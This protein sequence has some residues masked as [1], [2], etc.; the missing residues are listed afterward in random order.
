VQLVQRAVLAA[1]LG[2][3][4]DGD[5]LGA[6]LEGKDPAAFEALVRRHGPLVL[7][8]CRQVLRDDAAAEDAFQATFVALYQKAAAIR[9]QPALGGWLFRVARRTALRARRA[10][11][12]RSR[13]EARANPPGISASD[14]SWR[15]ACD[16][17]H[18]ELD[19]LPETY[20]STLV[21][22]YL[23]G[24]PR[25]EAA[26]RLGWSVTVLRGRLERARLRLRD[27]LSKRGIT[28]SA[29]LMTA[30]A[31]QAVP[32]RLVESATNG[33]ARPSVRVAE[34][35]AGAV[36]GK[37]KSLAALALAAGIV[38][39]IGLNRDDARANPESDRA[40]AAKPGTA[41]LDNDATDARPVAGRV[42]DPDGKP[43]AGARVW[44]IEP[45]QKARA[46][47]RTG[48]DGT[49]RLPS[50][51]MGKDPTESEWVIRI[52]ATHERF[53]LGLPDS[54]P[55]DGLTLR[56]VKDD[57]PIH[58]RVLDLQ[59]QPVAGV[60]VTPLKVQAAAGDSLN[61]WLEKL[62]AAEDQVN[63][64]TDTAVRRKI[65]PAP[66]LAPVKTDAQGRFTLR[67]VGRERLVELR[68]EGPTV[69]TAEF[70]V[71]T[72]LTDSVRVE[73]DPGNV[74]LGYRVFYGATFDFAADPTQPFEGVVTGKDTGKPIP[75]AIVSSV[76]PN[77]IETVADREG[78]YRLI[79]LSAGVHRLVA[80]PPTGE[81]FLPFR[82]EGGLPNSQRPV[83]L[84]FA[85][86]RAPWAEGTV[87][88]ARTGKPIAGASLHYF[89]FDP[90]GVLQFSGDA[91]A[92]GEAGRTDADGRFKIVALPGSGA[93]GVY[94][95]DGPYIE[96]TRRPLQGDA[97]FWTHER[98][99]QRWVQS[100]FTSFHALAVVE[101]D[102]KKPRR[103][104]ITLDPGESIKG[105]IL[106][107]DGKPLAGCRA[108]RLTEH[109]GWTPKPLG[110]EFTV[111]QVQSG[112]ARFVLFWHEER[113]LGAI[114]RPKPGEPATY[115]VR[116]KPNGAATGKLADK[117]GD[118]LSDSVIELYFRMP[119]EFGWSPWFPKSTVRTDAN[120]RFELPNLPEGVEFMLRYRPK[121]PAES[122]GREFRVKSGEALDLG[123]V[124]PR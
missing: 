43:V 90:A 70:R 66:F 118:P 21:L 35:A 36:S 9:K 82:L 44:I 18:A 26:R 102:P 48:D 61:G 95:P 106:D 114:W 99:R 10:A 62:K 110:A 100:Y 77:R 45:W 11:D 29:G 4:T 30:L 121:F 58:G 57:V 42:L 13:H 34:L 32:A 78:R 50:D 52:V 117:D 124:K 105:R 24:L 5:L 80:R 67:G 12:R 73:Y 2:Q 122:H 75:G 27:R 91:E 108:A 94:G 15:E 8:A 6:F 101:L 59:G 47:A 17:L 89:P 68:I 86:A 83:K 81:P 41:T 88:N 7:A 31:V 69:A 33:V 53:G 104:T 109:S 1:G 65:A 119:G 103:Y 116:L 56:L 87:T 38:L 97:L 14:L 28:L 54:K 71:M 39:G 23:E 98:V 3:R 76:F 40:A 84:D 111:G 51:E 93:I 46:V 96:A 92:F 19:R 63:V 115:D 112:K 55:G 85:L 20:R 37:F 79:G 16:L 74:K 120:G 113:K 123:D 25:D 107:P 22:C 64:I 72:R 60:T 49:F